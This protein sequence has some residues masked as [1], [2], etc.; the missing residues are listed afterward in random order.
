[1]SDLGNT[2]LRPS[3]GGLP[4]LT[5]YTFAVSV[6]AQS[7]NE[8]RSFAGADELENRLEEKSALAHRLLVENQNLFKQTIKNVRYRSERTEEQTK[9]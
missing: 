8:I 1:M 7:Y 4:D 5:N 3:G 9:D 2:E 6:I